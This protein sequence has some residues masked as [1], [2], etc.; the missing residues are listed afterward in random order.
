M[1][2]PLEFVFRFQRKIQPLQAEIIHYLLE[3]DGEFIGSYRTFSETLGKP[4]EQ[5][6]N[7]C[8]AVRALVEKGIVTVIPDTKMKTL[9][10][11]NKDWMERI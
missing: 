8:Q 4:R 5:G 7:I 1:N 10:G 9:I 11:L 3:H 2:V 6:T